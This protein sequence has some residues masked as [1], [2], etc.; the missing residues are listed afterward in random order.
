MGDEHGTILDKARDGSPELSVDDELGESLSLLELP[1]INST[2][3]EVKNNKNSE[4][5]NLN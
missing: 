2:K 3:P 5:I 1:L 4:A